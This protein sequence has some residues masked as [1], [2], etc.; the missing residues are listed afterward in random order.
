M[1]EELSRRLVNG[2][3]PDTPP[4]LVYK[5][6]GRGS[7]YIVLVQELRAAVGEEKT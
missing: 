2:Y 5:W 7:I 1:L 4:T 6:P 3:E